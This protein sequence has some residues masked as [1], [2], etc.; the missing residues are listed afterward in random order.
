MDAGA[1]RPDRRLRG[2][3]ARSGRC[4]TSTT[5]CSGPWRCSATRP[6]LAEPYRGA[7]PLDLDRR[8]PGHRSPAVRPGPPARAAGANLCAIGDPDQSIYGF[9]GADVGFFLRFRAGL[10]G[11]AGG[12]PHPQLPLDPHPGRG[13]LPGHPAGEPGAGA[14]AGRRPRTET[15]ERIVIQRAA[16]E[17]AEAELVVHTLERLLGGTSSSPSTA[18]GWAPATRPQ[19]SFDDIAI[20][21]RTEAQA[22][23]LVEALG[24]AG[25]PFQKRSHRP[26]AEQAG[27]RALLPR[28]AGGRRGGRRRGPSERAVRIWP[29]A[30]R[31]GAGI[32]LPPPPSCCGR[33]PSAPETT[34]TASSPRSPWAA[35]STPGT[36]A[37]RGSPSS[38]ST[39]PRAWSSP[40]SS[41]SAARTAC[42][43]SPCPALAAEADLAEERRLFFVGITRARSRLFLFHSRK[44]DVARRGGRL[45]ALA[46]PRRSRGGAPRPPGRARAARPGSRS[47]SGCCRARPR[48]PPFSRGHTSC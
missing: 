35:R 8:V 5:S 1:G 24:R 47:S 26:L 15:A 9:R 17:R 33:W 40:S 45:P 27:V 4:S 31:R 42:C 13:G 32:A 44:T 3:P 10:A 38:P 22:A 6:D 25:I 46:L 16:S 7:L 2:G 12:P 14:A 41:W 23:P 48:G 34:S 39:P 20:L 28:A 19:L 43:P 30:A 11:G 36:R 21:Y 18:A 29:G 37:P